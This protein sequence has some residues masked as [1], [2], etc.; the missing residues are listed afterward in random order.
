MLYKRIL[1][2]RDW[3]DLKQKEV[4]HVLGISQRLYSYYE[5]GQRM[6]PPDMLSKLADY[7]QVSVDY[8]MGR[9]DDPKRH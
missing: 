4:A 7:Y 3:H 8:L 2:L 5:T 1:D 9:T 6:I